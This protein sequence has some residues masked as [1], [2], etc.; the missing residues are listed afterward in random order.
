MNENIGSSRIP[1]TYDAVRGLL[2]IKILF[3]KKIIMQCIFKVVTVLNMIYGMIRK[4]L[5]LLLNQHF[6]IYFVNKPYISWI[7]VLSY[8]AIFMHKT[9]LIHSIK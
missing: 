8:V 1:S 9:R 5:F 4:K 2:Y 7:S 3:E 6:H